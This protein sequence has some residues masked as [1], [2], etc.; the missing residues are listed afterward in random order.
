V[1]THS[2]NNSDNT[3]PEM[4]HSEL[5]MRVWKEAMN[6]KTGRNKAQ[7]QEKYEWHLHRVMNRSE[8]TGEDT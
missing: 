4:P 6:G 7:A 5:M 3:K 1:A 8:D 2:D